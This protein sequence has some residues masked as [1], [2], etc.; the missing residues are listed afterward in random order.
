M[1][2]GIQ[3]GQ[4][5][6]FTSSL[7]ILH[8][9]GLDAGKL[10]GLG[11]VDAM[12]PRSPYDLGGGGSLLCHVFF[13]TSRPTISISESANHTVLSV[14]V[15]WHAMVAAPLGNALI[16]PVGDSVT[17]FSMASQ[18]GHTLFLMQGAQHLDHLSLQE[19]ESRLELSKRQIQFL[20]GFE[21]ETMMMVSIFPRLQ[22]LWFQDIDA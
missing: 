10:G 8:R 22:D 13:P 4:C 18:A 6:G 19:R 3:S 20:E 21:D 15:P 5:M 12:N 9:G 16:S 2:K 17:R 7:C 1:E 14:F 11:Q